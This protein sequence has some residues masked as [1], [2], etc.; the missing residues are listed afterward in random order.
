MFIIYGARSTMLASFPSSGTECQNCHERNTSIISIYQK[1]AHI[2]WIPLFPLGKA[3]YLTCNACK[4]NFIAK[5]I[6]EN[7]RNSPEQKDKIRTPWYYFIGSALILGLIIAVTIS[8]SFEN[9]ARAERLEKYFGD[10]K[11]GDMYVI[12]EEIERGYWY[13]YKVISIEGDNIQF[14]PSKYVYTTPDQAYN[15]RNLAE[16]STREVIFSNDDL[17]SFYKKEK[18]QDIIRNNEL[19]KAK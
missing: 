16:F 18:L 11:V 13:L 2:F 4:Q 14:I 7:I 1:Y 8:L 6:P 9:N 17:K 10:T 12:Q 3:I 5:E 19:I 15:D